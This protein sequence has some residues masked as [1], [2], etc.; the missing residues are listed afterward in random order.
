MRRNESMTIKGIATLMANLLNAN[1]YY[2]MMVQLLLGGVDKHGPGIYSL[3]PLGGSIEE[4]RVSATGSG[5]PM[6]YGI[7]EDQYREDITVKEG[8]NLTIRAIH[9]A[10]RSEEHTS[11]LQ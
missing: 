1:R 8:L 10:T 5:S 9:N 2:P 11:E 3:D 6:A 7:L 4:T